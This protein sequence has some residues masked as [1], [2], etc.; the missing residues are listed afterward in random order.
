MRTF[1]YKLIFFKIRQKI[2]TNLFLKKNDLYQYKKSIDIIIPIFNGF[3]YLQPLFDSILKNTD[4]PYRLIVI[5]DK[6]T[7]QHVLPYLSKQSKKHNQFVLIENSENIGFIRTVN[8]AVKLIE[9]DFFVLLN[10]DVEVPKNWL[11]RMINP[12]ISDENLASVTPFSNA[13]TIC[14][15]P[16]FLKDNDLYKGL[17]LKNIDDAFSKIPMLSPAIKIPTAIGFCMGVSTRVVKKI[18]FFDEIYGKGYA[19]ENDWCMR[20]S[21]NGF[22]HGIVNNLFIYHKH[23]GSFA[24]E[25]K[26]KLMDLNYRKLLKIYPHYE[27]IIHHFI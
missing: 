21:K 3:Q 25:E 11:S 17:S 16:N 10:S 27:E 8:K 14:S 20:A 13:A 9:S 1:S 19:E 12:L 26:S 7:D 5:N 22:S 23:G 24:S 6:S 15:F 4:I 18:G 2:F